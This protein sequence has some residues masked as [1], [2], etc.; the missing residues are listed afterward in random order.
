[1]TDLF[2][3]GDHLAGNA[4]SDTAFLRAMI[5]VE[6]AWLDGLVEAGIAPAAAAF[7]LSL[8]HI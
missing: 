5:A 3:P 4:M 8:I 1:M 2:W 7:S 6:Q